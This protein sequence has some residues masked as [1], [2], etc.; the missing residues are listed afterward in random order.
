MPIGYSLDDDKPVST[1]YNYYPEDFILIDSKLNPIEMMSVITTAKCYIGSSLHGCITAVSYGT[2]EIVCN[3]T[4]FNKVTGFFQHIGHEKY[5]VNK[6]IEIY[7]VFQAG[8]DF[9]Y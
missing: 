3:Y 8:F 4:N 6:P 7:D 1:I 5:L 2:P 9:E